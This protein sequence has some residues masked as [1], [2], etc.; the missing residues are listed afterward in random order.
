MSGGQWLMAPDGRYGM[1]FQADGNLVAYGPDYRPLWHA[2]TYDNP[3]ARFTLQADG[4]AVITAA[5]GRV[6]WHS[7][8]WGNPG[9]SL[10]A[11][12]DGNVVVYRS[13]DAPVLQL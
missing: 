4:N 1:A 2:G 8:A 12:S 6:L 11:Q 7:Y 3:G 10:R 5:D 13:G 9:S